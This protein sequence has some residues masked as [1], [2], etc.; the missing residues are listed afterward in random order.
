MM[1]YTG[2][3]QFRSIIEPFF[4]SFLLFFTKTRVPTLYDNTVQKVR[5]TIR[6]IFLRIFENTQNIRRVLYLKYKTAYIQES[7]SVKYV[8]V[9]VGT[10]KCTKICPRKYIYGIPPCNLSFTYSCVYICVQVII[11]RISV[12]KHLITKEPALSL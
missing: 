5:Y 1:E 4:V 10:M 11:S 3:D 12:N 8:T 2:P 6:Y 7:A 9:Y